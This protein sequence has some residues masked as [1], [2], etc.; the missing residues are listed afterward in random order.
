MSIADKQVTFCGAFNTGNPSRDEHLWSPR[1]TMGKIVERALGPLG[2][3]VDIDFR[4][5]GMANLRLVSKG[6]VDLGAIG[7]DHA[8]WAYEGRYDFVK[9]GPLSNLRAIAA[10]HFPAWLG[11]G[12]R[13]ETHVTDL[14]QIK[15]RQLPLRIVGANGP[16]AK[17][18]LEHYG[19]SRKLIES[20]GGK[21]LHVTGNALTWFI[22]NGDY[23]MIID[24][25]YA[26][27]TPEARHWWEAT[28]RHELRFLPLPDDLIQQIVKETGGSPGHIPHQ[29]MRGV[30][31]DVPTVARTPHLIYGRDDT[32]E[33]FAYLLAKTLD[34]KRNLFREVYLP[35]SYDPKTVARDNGLPLHPGAE[36][37]YREAGYVS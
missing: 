2:Y 3:Q 16:Q 7:G 27:N 5:F 26:A 19:L 1:T 12:V 4:G 35:Y 29:L 21:F 6:E 8:S 14:A 34:E 13:W 17:L 22:T 33:D 11:V 32:P 31:G 37:Y 10:I 9:D 18:V 28:V 30:V 24:A 20:W 23:D 15:E 25:I 36:R